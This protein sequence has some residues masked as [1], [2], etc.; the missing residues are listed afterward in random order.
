MHRALRPSSVVPPGFVRI[1][2]SLVKNQ[3]SD[4]GASD[5]VGFFKYDLSTQKWCPRLRYYVAS[6]RR[7]RYIGR[8]I[9]RDCD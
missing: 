3:Q 9:S 5:E 2:T 4:E 6:N 7:P 8:T 1:S